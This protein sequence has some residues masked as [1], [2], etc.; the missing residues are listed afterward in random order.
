MRVAPPRLIA[1]LALLG[2]DVTAF[3]GRDWSYGSIESNEWSSGFAAGGTWDGS[4]KHVYEVREVVEAPLAVNASNGTNISSQVAQAPVPIH[5][6]DGL[7]RKCSSKDGLE[8]CWGKGCMVE[9]ARQASFAFG[10]LVVVCMGSQSFGKLLAPFK[11]PMISLFILFGVVVGPFGFNL[12]PRNHIPELAWVNSLALGF[13]G[14]PASGHLHMSE[15]AETI[16][17]ALAILFGQ[18]FFVY[19]GTLV[20]C[21]LVG[22]AF[23]PFMAELS[24]AQKVAASLH[25]ACL[26]IARSPSSTIGI[27]RELNAK[28]PFSTVVLSVVV[29]MDPVVIV[30]FTCTQLISLAI[31]SEGGTGETSGALITLVSFMLQLVL[32]ALVGYIYGNL[33]PLCLP[34]AQPSSPRVRR[35]SKNSVFL[36]PRDWA[37]WRPAACALLLV[38]A[39]LLLL[40]LQ[41]GAPA[42]HLVE[43]LV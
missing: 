28:G 35:S 16:H 2:R 39:R 1:L 13:L 34:R 15:M 33:L 27:M 19:A 3:V 25:I 11:L 6:Y 7:G 42:P 30:A 4:Y 12:V 22:D 29:M 41:R 8:I 23:I 5:R 9:C 26:S 43:L 14:V 10:A 32:S 40:L 38:P 20:T 18:V 36:D 17:A 21:L 37:Y 24:S 31:T